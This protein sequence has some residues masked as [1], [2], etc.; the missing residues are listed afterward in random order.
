[1]S[2]EDKNIILGALDS[3]AVK[4]SDYSHVWTEGER[5][6]YEEAIRIISEN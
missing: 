5:C 2:E 4:L 1:M 6:I 3:L